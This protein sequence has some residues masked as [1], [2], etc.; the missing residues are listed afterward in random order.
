VY[1][2]ARAEEE[3]HPARTQLAMPFVKINRSKVNLHECVGEP[4]FRAVHDAIAD[5]FDQRENIVV[6]RI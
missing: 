6:F 3:Y 4:H 1:I 5:T 2:R